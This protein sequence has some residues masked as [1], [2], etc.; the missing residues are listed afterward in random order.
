MASE[1]VEA[2]ILNNL[3]FFMCHINWSFSHLLERIDL[4]NVGLREHREVD[5]FARELDLLDGR[6]ER[7]DLFESLLGSY[8][9]NNDLAISMA[10]G[11]HQTVW[12][13]LDGS[14]V[15][16]IRAVDSEQDVV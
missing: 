1:S 13:E 8:V 3:T 10:S 2:D 15:L 6:S 14:D 9:P 12:V 5:H 16:E 11:E 7:L 4:G